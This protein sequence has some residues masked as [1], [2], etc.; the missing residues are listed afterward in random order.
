MSERSGKTVVVKVFEIEDEAD[1]SRI[2]HEFELIRS[3]D[4]EGVARAESLQ[5]V[6]DQLILVLARTPGVTL[7]EL[8]SG[9]PI[10]FERFWPIATQLAEILARTHAAGVIHRAIKPANISIQAES[11]RVQL[12][13]FG[14]SVVLE[15]ER[16]RIYD[17]EVFANTL[18]YISPEQT[19]RTSR[20]VDFRSDLYSLGVTFYELLTG[21]RPFDS[22][23]PLEL[24]H[25]HLAR[26]PRAPHLLR[27]ELPLGLSRLV[28][29]LLAKAPE[30]RYQTALGLAADLRRIEALVRAGLDDA[31]LELGHDDVSST[32]RLPHQL[33]GREPERAALSE[34][35]ARVANSTERSIVALI[36]PA[37]VGKSAL[38]RELEAAVAGHGGYMVRGRFDAVRE[39]PYAG[40]AEA[41][42]SLFEQLLTESDARLDRW[43]RQLR[44]GLGNLASVIAELSPTLELILGPQAA[45]VQLD[46]T[47]S[48]NRIQVA[49]ERLLAVVCAEGRPLV[50][51]LQD[52]HCAGP[53]SVRLL[54]ALIHGQHGPLLLLA[55]MQLDDVDAE[56]PVHNFAAELAAHPRARTLEL[57]GLEPAAIEA[58]PG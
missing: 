55:T 41:F 17:D 8:V 9:R 37:G 50:L 54:E 31:A 46:A 48:R 32:L 44:D 27:P 5:R 29:K 4:F 57:R 19:G 39:T 20:V 49:V 47:E 34:A 35:F 36:G 22:P 43:R 15:S 3:L 6:G 45:P 30:R 14:I 2:Q 56:H 58:L 33:Y 26:E 25:A 23:T 21:R 18:P 42:T 53:T 28:M 10:A 24:I 16:R 12:T 7:A 51:V 40:F 13:D 11:G 38:M 52:L 1:E